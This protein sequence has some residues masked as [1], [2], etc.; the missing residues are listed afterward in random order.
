MNE[1]E[2]LA[3][4]ERDAAR[5]AL[6]ES[7]ELVAL[8]QRYYGMPDNYHVSRG[9]TGEPSEKNRTYRATETCWKRGMTGRTVGIAPGTEHESDGTATVAITYADG[10]HTIRSAASFNKKKIATKVREHKES[11]RKIAECAR[12]APIGNVE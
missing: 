1:A 7:E 2:Q 3:T 6:R 5:R 12:L 11:Q 9:I 4:L 8:A 10:T